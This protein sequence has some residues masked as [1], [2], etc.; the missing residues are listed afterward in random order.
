MTFI[1]SNKFDGFSGYKL[2]LTN[3]TPRRIR[4]NDVI[5]MLKSSLYTSSDYV[6]KAICMNLDTEQKKIVGLGKNKKN[7]F[8]TAEGIFIIVNYIEGST[9]A[10]FRV[11][12][13]N[14]LMEYIN[15]DDKT[16]VIRTEIQ[17]KLIR[18]EIQ[19]KLIRTK[20]DDTE[21]NLRMKNLLDEKI[22]FCNTNS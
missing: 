7:V 6:Y 2:R 15:L 8:T 5:E 22:T 18:T 14:K 12:H 4:I 1:D 11:Y 19:P 13:L 9:A 10:K 3:E 17:S 16:K 20:V 21:Y